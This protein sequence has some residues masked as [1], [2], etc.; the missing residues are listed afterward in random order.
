VT[1]RTLKEWL[2]RPETQKILNTV[3]RSVARSLQTGSLSMTFLNHDAPYNTDFES[4]IEEIQS[5]LGLFILEKEAHLQT[6]FHTDPTHFYFYLQ[7]SFFNYW[8]DK[9][10]QRDTDPDRYLYKRCGDILRNAP[11]F[12]TKASPAQPFCYSMKPDSIA[13]PLLTT[14]DVNAVAF[15]DHLV[16]AR[17]YETINRKKALMALAEYFW[18]KIVFLWGNQPVW[19]AISDL[20]TWIALYVP[21]KATPK[22]VLPDYDDIDPESLPDKKPPPDE[23]LFEPAKVEHWAQM[24]VNRL[25]NKEKNAFYLRWHN[26]CND[27]AIARQL[28]YRGTSG[29]QYILN[30]T[31]KKLRS[32]LN[33]LPWLSPDDLNPAAFRLFFKTVLNNLKNETMTP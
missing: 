28:G 2:G 5:H 21:L 17:Q 14:E 31:E 19:I 18:R 32:F 33:G 12:Y 4:L 29:A 20:L 6:V 22:A 25:T 23:S 24:F 1:Q 9:T 11:A 3:A 8:R 13:I 7:K 30:K 26:Q 15:P 16:K 10:R 27:T